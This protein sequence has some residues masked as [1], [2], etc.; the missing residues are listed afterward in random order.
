[1]TITGMLFGGEQLTAS[2]T[3]VDGPTTS[4]TWQWARGNS[5]TGSFA[6]ISGAT[7]ADY[8][9]VAADVG[10]YLRATASYTDPQGSGKNA[11]AVTGG[12]VE[13]GN[14]APTF[15]D[16]SSATRTVA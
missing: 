6:D 14:S 9:L 12:A 8:T 13:A 4:V 16:G 15:V 3:D 10:K 7:S 11:N 1:M 5:A 2:L